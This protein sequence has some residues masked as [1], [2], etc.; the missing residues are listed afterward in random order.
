MV[1]FKGKKFWVYP[2]LVDR[3]KECKRYKSFNLKT[4]SI[5][6]QPNFLFMNFKLVGCCLTPQ[7]MKAS[8]LVH[9]S[10]YY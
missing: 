4:Y 10:Y 9:Y 7:E 6:Q 5:S 1:T 3:N 2:I 8:S